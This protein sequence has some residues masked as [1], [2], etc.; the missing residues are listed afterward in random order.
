MLFG[1]YYFFDNIFHCI[2][3]A[4]SGLNKIYEMCNAWVSIRKKEVF[5]LFLPHCTLRIP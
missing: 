4:S 3:T 1:V 5:N 2:K